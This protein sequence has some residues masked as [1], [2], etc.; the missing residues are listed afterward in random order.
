MILRWF[1]VTKIDD[2]DFAAM[3]D[4]LADILGKQAQRVIPFVKEYSKTQLINKKRKPGSV[5]TSQELKIQDFSF[6]CTYTS[7]KPPRYPQF[8]LIV[9]RIER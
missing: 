7:G 1:P 3:H 9:H 8:T 4:Y 6:S 5:S 2:I